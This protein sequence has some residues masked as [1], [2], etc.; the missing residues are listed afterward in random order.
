VARSFGLRVR[1]ITLF[2]FGGAASLEDEAKRPR[3]EAVMAGAGPIASLVLGAVLWGIGVVVPQAQVSA[4]AGWL[5]FINVWLGL[6][7]LIPG[8]PMDGGRIL[9]AI[10]WKVRGD[11]YAA[12]RN[13]ATVGRAFG[14]ALIAA[15][16][17]LILQLHNPFNGIWLALI[18]WFLS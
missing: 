17:Y 8:F 15:G 1:D 14:Y 10:L 18:G 4:I 12:T 6:F 2:I 11:R 3:D 16:V 9:R 5:G 7:N 13:A